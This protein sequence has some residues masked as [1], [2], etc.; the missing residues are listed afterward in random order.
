[1]I[2]RARQGD[3]QTIK[4]LVDFAHLNPSPC[5]AALMLLEACSHGHL[6]AAE[7]LKHLFHIDKQTIQ[8]FEREHGKDIFATICDRADNESLID[9]FVNTFDINRVDLEAHNYRALDAICARGSLDRIKWF[10]RHF[11]LGRYHFMSTNHLFDSP[12][13]LARKYNCADVVSYL[14]TEFSIRPRQ[15]RK[16]EQ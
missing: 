7:E 9:W 11:G 1:M 16:L 8:Q 2:R 14:E 15:K 6:R 13:D 4:W 12:I 10:I 5:N 3:V